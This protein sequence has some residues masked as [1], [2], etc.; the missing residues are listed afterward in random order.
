MKFKLAL[1]FVGIGLLVMSC[2]GSGNPEGEDDG[3]ESLVQLTHEQFNMEEML[4]GNL[5]VIGFEEVVKCNGYIVPE[6]GGSAIVSTLLPGRVERIYITHGQEVS[7]G[8][9]LFELSGNDMINLQKE[10]AGTANMLKK[11]KAEYDRLKSLHADNIGAG[12]DLISAEAEYKSAQATY[13]GLQMKIR[14]L[15]LDA[16]QVEDGKF[17]SG[18]IIRSPIN[19]Y[20][21]SLNIVSGQY[22]EPQAALAEVVDMNSLQLQISVFEKDMHMLRPG[23]DVR[24][25]FVGNPDVTHEARLSTIGKKV[26][27][28]SKAI[29]CVAEPDALDKASMF[30]NAYVEARIIT[31]VDSVKAIPEEAVISSGGKQYVLGL[32]KEEGNHYLFRKI[33][34]ETGRTFNGFVEIVNPPDLPRLLT[35]GAYNLYVE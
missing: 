10:Y 23:Q 17:A 14:L 2:G 20:I 15:G 19:G 33:E 18:F 5:E 26:N 28:E 6:P 27:Q 4:F 11:Y 8:Q 25:V 13:A 30:S 7:K 3:G 9:A 34:V 24:F 32:E 16:E 12:K 29:S 21:S 1:L 35:K 22:A 31:N